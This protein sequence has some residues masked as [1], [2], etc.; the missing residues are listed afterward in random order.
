MLYC[1][2]DCC[3]ATAVHGILA[4]F[5]HQVAVTVFLLSFGLAALDAIETRRTVPHAWISNGA[6]LRA[7]LV[8][9]RILQVSI[10]G[11]R[12]L[13]RGGRGYRLRL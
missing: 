3:S 5:L 11:S 1:V 13:P 2:E 8:A 12:S 4:R 6:A 10:F 9:V 7:E